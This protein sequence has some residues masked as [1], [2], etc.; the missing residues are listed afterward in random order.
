MGIFT[1]GEQQNTEYL[2]LKNSPYTPDTTTCNSAIV[3]PMLN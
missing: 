2:K 1:P 3:V